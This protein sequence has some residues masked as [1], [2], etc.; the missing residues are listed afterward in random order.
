MNARLCGM[1]LGDTN[2]LLTVSREDNRVIT[3]AIA[4]RPNFIVTISQRE[5][6]AAIVFC[7]FMERN[8]RLSE[9]SQSLLVSLSVRSRY[10]ESSSPN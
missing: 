4:L 3:I 9:R 7:M 2:A 1:M 8:K 6:K 5:I 10:W